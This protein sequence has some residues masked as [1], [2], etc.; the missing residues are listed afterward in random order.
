MQFTL[1]KL[2]KASYAFQS[3]NII[4]TVRARY[5]YNKY[6]ETN[7][8]ILWLEE[9]QS[10]S[11]HIDSHSSFSVSGCVCVCVRV[12]VLVTYFIRLPFFLFCSY[13]QPVSCVCTAVSSLLAY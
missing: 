2:N 10:S 9:S 12:C 7:T 11:C 5:L 4:D 6:L 3:T 8:L 1:R 13:N